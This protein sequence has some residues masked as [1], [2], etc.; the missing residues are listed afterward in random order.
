MNTTRRRFILG[1]GAFLAAPAA[2]IKA[3]EAAFAQAEKAAAVRASFLEMKR[4]NQQTFHGWLHGAWQQAQAPD[5]GG[6]LVPHKFT[7]Q[8]L[9]L[10]EQGAPL[11]SAVRRVKVPP[12]AAELDYGTFDG[13]TW[14]GYQGVRPSERKRLKEGEWI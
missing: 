3:V 9:G 13:A 5:Y 14:D 12:A 7:D 8:I 10:V 1:V 2:G 6:Y 4:L 11:R